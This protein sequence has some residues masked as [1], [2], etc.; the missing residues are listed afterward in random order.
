[1]YS[2]IILFHW[3]FQLLFSARP[4]PVFATQPHVNLPVC[5]TLALQNLLLPVHPFLTLN[6]SDSLS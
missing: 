1:M 5:H 4:C 2:H 3:L 6:S